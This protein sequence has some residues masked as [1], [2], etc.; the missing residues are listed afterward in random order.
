MTK[1]YLDVLR[2]DAVTAAQGLLGWELYNRV[3]G[4]LVGGQIIETEAY[5]QEDPACHTYRGQ[6]SRNAPMFSAAGTVYIYFTYGMHWC[7]N[8]V[9]GSE[10]HGEAVLLRGLQPLQG[11][12]T[13][14]QN[15]NAAVDKNLC[16]GPAKLV[17]ALGID[18]AWT[19][20]PLS[21]TS[22]LLRPGERPKQI[23]TTARIGISEG[24]EKLW[25]FTS[26]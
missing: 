8:L 18:P 3:N 25:R 21:E 16:N 2:T 24:R 12:E 17:Q 5:T 7:M 15:R 6:T 13:M 10:G 9:T 20:K 26:Q 23:R 4:Q 19:G 1:N 11:I 22:L 14:R